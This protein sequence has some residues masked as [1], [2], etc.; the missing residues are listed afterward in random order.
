M[1]FT[2]LKTG[3]SVALSAVEMQHGERKLKYIGIARRK[4]KKITKRQ[5]AVLGPATNYTGRTRLEAARIRFLQIQEI[6]RAH[7]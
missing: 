4:L 7:V 6:G 2:K 5:A 1:K 3:R